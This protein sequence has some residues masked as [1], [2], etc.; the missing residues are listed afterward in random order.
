MKVIISKTVDIVVDI[1]EGKEKEF[2]GESLSESQFIQWADQLYIDT[3]QADNSVESWVS[4]DTITGIKIENPP[5]ELKAKYTQEDVQ[6]ELD[7]IDRAERCYECTGYGDDYSVNENG[8]W[9][10]NCD[11]CPFNSDNEE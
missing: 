2:F 6:K 5:K 10:S 8:E 3:P 9:V 4:N 7:E 11:T 1:P